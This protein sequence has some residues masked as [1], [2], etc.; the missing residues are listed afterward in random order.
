M[1]SRVDN[2]TLLVDAVDSLDSVDATVDA[3]SLGQVSAVVDAPVG[4][5]F[6]GVVAKPPFHPHAVSSGNSTGSTIPLPTPPPLSAVVVIV[7]ADKATAPPSLDGIVIRN[8][9]NCVAMVSGQQ[10][11][12]FFSYNT[13]SPGA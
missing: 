8:Q 2:P 4:D 1:A 10:S 9:R 5:N 13:D 12:R 11:L 6:L 7:L 3:C